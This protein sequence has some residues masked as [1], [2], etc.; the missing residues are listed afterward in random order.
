MR[1]QIQLFLV[2][3]VFSSS[4]FGNAPLLRQ[5]L[6]ENRLEEAVPIC[7]QYEVL[8][9]RDDDVYFA[10]AWVYFRSFRAPAAEAVMTK[11]KNSKTLPEYHLLLIYSSV[12]SILQAPEEVK[13]LEPDDRKIYEEKLKN[14]TAYLEGQLQG[15]FNSVEKKETKTQASYRLPSGTLKVKY[16]KKIEKDDAKLEH[17]LDHEFPHYIDIV[18][19]KKVCWGE[20]KKELKFVDGKCIDPYGE[21]LDF[22]TETTEEEFVVEV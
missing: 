5:L 12:G 8:P 22:I 1:A 15:Y 10:C 13:K 7:R 14:R 21:V 11:L 9:S 6:N 18:E 17:Y 3:L 2:W 19:T 4:A 20:F 16:K